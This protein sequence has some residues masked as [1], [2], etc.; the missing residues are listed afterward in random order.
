MLS[1]KFGRLLAGPIGGGKSVCNVHEILRQASLQQA[2]P[3][4]ER[5][6]RYLVLRNTRDQIRSTVQKTL[7]EWCPPG[8][9]GEWKST[10]NTLYVRAG[11]GDKTTINCE[12]MLVALDDPSDVRKALSLEATGVFM[13][14][15]RELHPEVIQGISSRV[16]RYPPP[17]EGVPVTNP[18][19]MMDTNMPVE[20]TWHWEQFENPPSNWSVH[21]QPRAIL[22][23]DE[24][25]HQQGE[26][27]VEED[28]IID[29][30]D[31]TWWVNPKADNLKNLHKD[32]YKNNIPGKSED[33]IRTF[34][35]CEYGRAMNGLPVYE[36]TF[37]P[38]FHISPED[39]RPLRSAAHPIVIGLDYGRTP[40]AVFMQRDVRG[41]VNV[42]SELVSQNMGIEMFL[43]TKLKPHIAQ[44]YMGCHFV[45]APDPAGWAKT[46]V[47]EVSPTDVVKRAGFKVVKPPTNL[48]ELR[49]Q[50]VERFLVKQIDGKA[51]ILIDPKKCP[52]LVKG[53]RY[54]Y[55]YKLNKNGSMVDINPEK[56]Q[57]SHGND[58]MQYGCLILDAG[59]SGEMYGTKAREV[60]RVQATGWT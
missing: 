9:A 25:L 6:T 42:L 43:D 46:Q 33:F 50:A 7:F 41:R 3:R 26:E 27:P 18:C 14:E 44:E 10:E 13:N 22:T 23:F 8:Q 4:G 60:E 49:I 59:V 16:G 28:G 57:F 48:P 55:R 38:D 56:N 35:R 58:A 17:K 37:R 30:F 15:W 45:V 32:Y 20:E 40:A 34:L 2:D 36:K 52:E 21:L 11:L 47:G 51:A 54:G 31:R 53:F 39:L 12:I 19:I 5:R 1:P 29:A 24:Y